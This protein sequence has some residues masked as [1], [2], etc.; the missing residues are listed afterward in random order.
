M[1]RQSK[2]RALLLTVVA[3]AAFAT[4]AT[5]ARPTDCALTLDVPR[6]SE[7]GTTVVLHVSGLTGVGGID[8]FTSWRNRVEEAH[9]F[10]VPGIT[11]FDFIYRAWG[12][13]EE[14]PLP[15]LEP[16]TYRVHAIDATGCEATT[17]FR[18][19]R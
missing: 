19:T 2:A 16:G 6:T 11:E 8:I 18:V 12:P 7:F 3:L 9:L 5:A 1:R 4:P 15:P 13:P 17:I 14:P 10:L